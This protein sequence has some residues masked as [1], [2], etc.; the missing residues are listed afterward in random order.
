LGK[1][2][3]SDEDKKFAT[4][5][6]KTDEGQNVKNNNDIDLLGFGKKIDSDEDKKFATEKIKT[7]E[8]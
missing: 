1:Q 8:G 2:V 7:S 6:I 5:K 4:E 3:D